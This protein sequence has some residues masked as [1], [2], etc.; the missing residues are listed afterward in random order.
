M[1]ESQDAAITRDKL[2]R[3][4]DET[5]NIDNGLTMWILQTPDEWRYSISSTPEVYKD[6]NSG[7]CSDVLPHYYKSVGHAAI[8]N[9]YRMLRLLVN[10]MYIHMAEASGG[11][12]YSIEAYELR[13]AKGRMER[14]SK[15]L[16]DAISSQICYMKKSMTHH[17][18]EPPDDSGKVTPVA[19]SAGLLAWPLAGGYCLSTVRIHRQQFIRHY[20]SVI[21]HFLG[22]R[23]LETIAEGNVRI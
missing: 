10:D 14:L 22:D 3:L 17:G 20:L 11:T 23:I 15:D 21:A 7:F 13:L 8:W 9:Q 1:A 12:D 2:Q 5:Q 18:L 16:C 19:H 4:A 6:P